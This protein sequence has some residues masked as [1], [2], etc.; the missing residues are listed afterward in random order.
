MSLNSNVTRSTRRSRHDG[1]SPVLS[2]IAAT[3]GALDP[4][5]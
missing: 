3:A 4:V 5:T 2:S 1:D